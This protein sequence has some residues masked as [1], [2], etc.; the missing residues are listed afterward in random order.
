MSKLHGIEKA[1]C[2][3]CPYRKDVPSGVWAEE[4]YEKLHQYDGE[5][6]NQLM[7]EGTALFLCHQKDGN[8]CAGWLACHGS[9]SLLALRLH[10]DKVDEVI[11]GYETDVPVFS[12]GAEA[13]AH[14][15]AEI[16]EPGEKARR[17]MDQLT[18]KFEREGR[19][20]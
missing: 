4:E 8:L 12:S 10:A 6:I 13:A 1:P 16:E 14:G 17:V 19:G 3:S 5:I 7:Q 20:G 15:M 9:D 11:W 18:R 2:K